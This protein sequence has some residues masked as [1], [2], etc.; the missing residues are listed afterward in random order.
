MKICQVGTGS[1][2][3]GPGVAGGSERFVHYLA[4]G[5]QAIGHEV[6]VVDATT[7]PRG[8]TP[9]RLI[10]VAPRAHAG[11]N[12]LA[13]AAHG[14]MFGRAVAKRLSRLLREERFDVVNFHSQFSGLLGI[15]VARRLGVPA[16][17][18]MHNPLWSDEAACRSLR[19]RS[20]FWMERRAETRADAPIYLSEAIRENRRRFFGPESADASV[21][22]LGIDESWFAR[23]R[24]SAGVRRKYTPNGEAVLLQVARIAPYKNQMALLKALPQI[25]RAVPTVRAVFVGPQDSAGYLSVLRREVAGN[26]LEEK[27]VFAGNVAA[28]ELAQLYSLAAVF[29]LPSLQENCPQ[30]LLEA[31]A[32]GTAVVASDIAPLRPMLQGVAPM[33]PPRDHVALAE[34]LLRLLAERKARARPARAA[35]RRAWERYRWEVIAGQTADVYRTMMPATARAA[36]RPPERSL[37]EGGP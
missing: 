18:T 33:V 24:P 17:F 32:Q 15:P 20:L 5:L 31:M 10:E 4:K 36:G 9:Y 19:A 27:V 34:A 22:P 21:V 28:E 29:V 3:V 7:E 11:S 1:L 16:F 12:P 8:D 30:S 14:L 13:H 23:R 2:P 37:A 26:G 35:K 25:V 6:T